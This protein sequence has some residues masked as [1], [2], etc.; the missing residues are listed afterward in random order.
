MSSKTYILFLKT[1]HL[2]RYLDFD[3]SLN[4]C[5][6]ES[7]TFN[8]KLFWSLRTKEHARYYTWKIR[9]GTR[10]QKAGQDKIERVKKNFPVHIK[11]YISALCMHVCISVYMYVSCI[12]AMMLCN[13]VTYCLRSVY[14]SRLT[15]KT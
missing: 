14:S 1:H 7:P 12:S 11:I 5:V 2:L 6:K 15:H 10:I 8:F 3:Q 9:M 13:V 4:L